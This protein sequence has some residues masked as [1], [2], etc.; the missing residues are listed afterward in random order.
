MISVYFRQFFGE[1]TVKI[2]AFLDI[3]FILH[4][5]LMDFHNGEK[6]PLSRLF[7]PAWRKSKEETP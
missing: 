6:A 2:A 5:N 1:E 4:Y 3:A 7:S